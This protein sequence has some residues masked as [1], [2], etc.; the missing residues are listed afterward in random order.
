M[1][2]LSCGFFVVLADT[3]IK[4]LFL[5]FDSYIDKYEKGKC[6][7]GNCNVDVCASAYGTG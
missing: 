2:N 6:D 3:S 7:S 1:T 5:Q 4:S